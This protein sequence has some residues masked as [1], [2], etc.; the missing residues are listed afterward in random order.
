MASRQ[1]VEKA[2]EVDENY[3]FVW[4]ESRESCGNGED[5]QLSC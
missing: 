4:E 5:E 1:I 2:V 3:V